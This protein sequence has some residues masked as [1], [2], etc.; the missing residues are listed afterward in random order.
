MKKLIGNEKLKKTIAEYI[1]CSRL[2]QAIIIEGEQGL[3]KHTA[4]AFI[5]AAALCKSENAPCL[6]CDT[7]RTVLEKNHTD[8]KYYAPEK[9]TFTVDMARAIRTEAYLKPLT[10]DY[11]IAILEHCELMNAEAQNALLKVLEEPPESAL[12]ILLTENAGAF[13]TTV[14]SRCLLL[15]VT[16]LS[17][18]EVSNYLESETDKSPEEILPAVMLSEGNIGKALMFLDDEDTEEIRQL[19]KRFYTNL[20]DKNSIELLKCAYEAEKFGAR[21]EVL[22]ILYETIFTELKVSNGDKKRGLIEAAEAVSFAIE[23]LNANGNKSVV[24]NNMCQ[25]LIKASKY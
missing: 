1:K 23:R 2:P 4:A 12:F 3:G 18:E 13:L 24:L 15:R 20:C 6:N 14:L 19:S 7:C 22:K 10:S 5:A 11:N 9:S 21:I 25:K 16:P 17:N 8:I